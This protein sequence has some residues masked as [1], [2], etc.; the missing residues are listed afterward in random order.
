MQGQT[1]TNVIWKSHK[2]S[3]QHEKNYLIVESIGWQ[4]RVQPHLWS[5]P[6]DI[7]EIENTYV[8]KVE[9]AGMHQ[10]EF[11]IQLEEN[12]LIISGN[13][14]DNHERRAYHQMEVR[15]GE[16]STVVTIPG[17]IDSDKASAEYDDGF[18]IVKLPKAGMD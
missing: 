18:L 9:I 12:Y 7:F 5:P 16:F 13:R 6:T 14:H 15:F 17:P 8:I 10:Q 3:A 4:V 11:S 1:M 2:N